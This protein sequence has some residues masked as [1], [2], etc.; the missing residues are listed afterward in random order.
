MSVRQVN[1][2]LQPQ[3]VPNI[4]ALMEGSKQRRAIQSSLAKLSLD[5]EVSVARRG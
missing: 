4:R 3:M 2:H 5:A 1:V